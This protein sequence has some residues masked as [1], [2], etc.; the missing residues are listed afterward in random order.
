MAH[1]GHEVVIDP[2][3]ARVLD[4]VLPDKPLTTAQQTM[5]GEAIVAAQ[6][7]GVQ[8]RVYRVP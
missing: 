2:T 4:L 5:L 8:I 6:S 1:G 3:T 7:M